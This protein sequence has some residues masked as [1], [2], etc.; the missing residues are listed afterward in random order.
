M[1]TQLSSCDESSLLP[2]PANMSI[3]AY[4]VLYI[5]LML[6]RYRHLSL[7]ELNRHLSEN[8]LIGRAYNN[9]TISK[10]VNTLR[11]A[12]C[13]I[14]KASNRNDYQYEMSKTPFTLQLSKEEIEVTGKLLAVLSRQADENLTRDYRDFLDHLS[15]AV[16]LPDSPN[17]TSVDEPVIFYELAYHRKLM[18]TY[19]QYCQDAF[20]LRLDYRLPNSDVRL[21][22]YVEPQ[23][24]IQRNDGLILYALD[25]QSQENLT[26]KLS[27]IEDVKQLPSKNRRVKG[28]IVTTFALYD[29]LA[30]SYRLY[31]GEWIIY[32][33]ASELHIKS[34]LQDV[35]TFLDRVMKYGTGCQILTPERLRD[36]LRERTEALLKALHTSTDLGSLATQ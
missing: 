24:V 1:L 13:H 16:E 20:H 34:K 25:C 31:P 3:S 12:G 22:L 11:I 21:V 10:Y 28:S 4:R 32:Q 6:V 2:P 29:R 30:K 33:N 7:L 8:P 9:E 23:D 35:D 5:L 27:R 18:N 15:W 17:E 36:C 26:L 14:P 19:R